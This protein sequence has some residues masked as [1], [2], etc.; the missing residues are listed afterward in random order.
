MSS[1]WRINGQGATPGPSGSAV[2]PE[3]SSSQKTDGGDAVNGIDGRSSPSFRRGYSED[4]ARIAVTAGNRPVKGPAVSSWP[5]A[6]RSTPDSTPVTSPLVSG[7]SM[8]SQ[9][10]PQQN[11]IWS[12]HYL[13]GEVDERGPRACRGAPPATWRGDGAAAAAASWRDAEVWKD[14]TERDL[15]AG[16]EEDPEHLGLWHFHFDGEVRAGGVAPRAAPARSSSGGSP[17][18]P[19]TSKSLASSDGAAWEKL[20]PRRAAGSA[21]EGSPLARQLA[22]TE[23]MRGGGESNNGGRAEEE[24]AEGGEEQESSCDATWTSAG[25]RGS[26]GHYP[27]A[28][29]DGERQ[30]ILKRNSKRKASGASA[31]GGR[32]GTSEGVSGTM[33][34]APAAGEEEVTAQLASG[35]SG[36]G[37]GGRERLTREQKRA[38]VEHAIDGALEPEAYP[39]AW[40]GGLSARV[41]GFESALAADVGNNEVATALRRAQV[42][43]GEYSQGVDAALRQ[44]AALHARRERVGRRL[45]LVPTPGDIDCL[46]AAMFSERPS[47]HPQDH[48]SGS[49]S[50]PPERMAAAESPTNAA[51][52]PGMRQLSPRAAFHTFCLSAMEA[53][54]SLRVRA[55]VEACAGRQDENLQVHVNRASRGK[56]EARLALQ[57]LARCQ[58]AAE[59]AWLANV[60]ASAGHLEAL[61]AVVLPIERSFLEE[62]IT[63]LN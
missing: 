12:F 49:G 46:E 35:G 9:G 13:P 59:A 15:L 45:R 43:V 3:H 52:P 25:R 62:P 33:S 5:V 36:A 17:A 4:L 61:A 11:A 29:A 41:A 63:V 32:G 47:E 23:E 30:H 2:A 1:Y 44:V 8:C 38:A 16:A 10:E 57:S 20:R 19:G 27:L 7:S 31:E 51:G 24:E 50:L 40:R 37:G 26:N 58:V 6:D 56:M 22:G 60:D 21:E 48:L 53:E 39:G 28:T 42:A 54:S 14:V 34:L 55:A 18:I